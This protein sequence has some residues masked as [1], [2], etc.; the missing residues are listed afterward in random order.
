VKITLHKP[1]SIF[2]RGQRDNMEDCIYPEHGSASTENRLFIV[3]DG[4]GGHT[5]GEIASQLAC[6]GFAGFFNDNPPAGLQENC[7]EQ[8]FNHVQA[9]FDDFTEH[10]PESRGMG[11]TLVLVYLEEDKAM[12][13]H[14]GDS[15][16]YHYRDGELLWKTRDHKLVREWVDQGLI[17]EEEARHHAMAN[18]ITRAIQGAKVSDVRPDLHLITDLRPGDYL[19]L[20]T[21]GIYESLTDEQLALIM[22]DNSADVAKMNIVYDLCEANSK[23]N[24]SAYLLNINSVE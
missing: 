14:C 18:R 12:V 11:T 20:C 2:A 15:R 22:Q 13:M 3:C 17:S 19:L 1:V 10:H 4:M 21:D 8:A 23:D 6:D 9:Q 7:F 16:F 5:K 24:F